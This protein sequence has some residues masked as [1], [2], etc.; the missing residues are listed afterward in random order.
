MQNIK[1]E[2]NEYALFKG[3][4][5]RGLEGSTKIAHLVYSNPVLI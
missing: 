2:G 1:P 3:R 4:L 5:E